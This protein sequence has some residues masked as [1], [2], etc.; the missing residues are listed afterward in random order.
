[1]VLRERQ[2]LHH[3]EM[4][5][6]MLVTMVVMLMVTMVVMLMLMMVTMVMML[7]MVVGSCENSCKSKLGDTYK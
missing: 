1:M 5:V 3:R 7:M 4:L 2:L 6:V